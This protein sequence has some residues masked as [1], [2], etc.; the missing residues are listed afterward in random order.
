MADS[1]PIS[2]AGALANGELTIALYP[3]QHDIWYGTAAELESEGLVPAGYEW[4]RGTSRRYFVHNGIECGVARKRKPGSGNAPWATIDYWSIQRYCKD[5]A[6]GGARIYE[7]RR[8]LEL[9]LWWHS[10]HGD[11]MFDLAMQARRDAAF[12]GFLR[13]AIGSAVTNRKG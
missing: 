1:I 12:Q 8:A 4:P 7:K 5:R 9:E 11:R 3:R 10:P 6:H 13:H 2:K